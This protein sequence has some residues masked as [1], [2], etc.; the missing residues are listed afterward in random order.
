MKYTIL[1]ILVNLHFSVLVGNTLDSTY[2]YKLNKASKLWEFDS[3][4]LYTTDKSGNTTSEL[5]QI[6]IG[7]NS[8]QS[9][10]LIVY[11]YDADNKLITKEFQ[12]WK[13]I[14][15]G[16]YKY[17]YTYDSNNNLLSETKK[18]WFWTGT[19]NIWRNDY[20]TTFQYD[21]KN[22]MVSKLNKTWDTVNIN[23][24]NSV[25]EQYEYDTL[26][27]K[28]IDRFFDNWNGTDW[29]NKVQNIYGYNNENNMISNLYQ[30]YNFSDKVWINSEN[31]E[32]T[33]DI[34]TNTLSEKTE[35]IWNNNTWQNL[36]KDI[37]NYD[38]GNNLININ[39][40]IW[41]PDSSVWIDSDWKRSYT[42]DTSNNMLTE[43]E[44]VWHT[45]YWGNHNQGI[46]TY[47]S[48]N[49][50]LSMV[51]KYWSWV[52]G[53][54]FGADSSYNFY[55]NKT[56]STSTANLT[57]SNTNVL[58]YPN[59]T[60]G[61]IN[62]DVKKYNIKTIVIRDLHGRVCYQ[63]TNSSIHSSVDLS[64]LDRGIYVVEILSHHN[65]NSVFRKIILN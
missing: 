34:A 23:W 55:S 13:L 17:Y 4:V 28:T 47:D 49:N 56:F 1:T 61:F 37:N 44:E 25:E 10:G 63:T 58:I 30:E 62:I 19:T 14:M 5:T 64:N 40:K 52:K 60:Y 36:T 65:E 41:N 7:N 59:P 21:S 3:K 32:Y 57:D 45:T 24:I 54:F 50:K 39:P 51:K 53:D 20:Q 33:Y 11:E 27:N 8:W 43:L 12:D 18:D 29:V 31:T 48:L 46:Y 6:W 15:Q 38:I 16:L 2:N 22:R 9:S 35:K 26:N 42:Y